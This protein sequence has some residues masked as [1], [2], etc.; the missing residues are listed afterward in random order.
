MIQSG[1][2]GQHMPAYNMYGSLQILN[3]RIRKHSVSRLSGVVNSVS[4]RSQ[5]LAAR[6]S[7]AFSYDTLRIITI[8]RNTAH[9]CCAS[10][11]N[12]AFLNLF[13][14]TEIETIV[15]ICESGVWSRD[16]VLQA[17]MQSDWD[18]EKALALLRE[19]HDSDEPK[20][21]DESRKRGTTLQPEICQCGRSVKRGGAAI[22]CDRCP[23]GHTRDCEK[24]EKELM[25]M[26]TI[27]GSSKVSF[28][29]SAT[30][31][32]IDAGYLVLRTPPELEHHRGLHRCT[33]GSLQQ[34]LGMQISENRTAF[35]IRR[36]GTEE[37]NSD[38]WARQGLQG[39][40]PTH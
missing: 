25:S 5:L 34:R 27:G 19:A 28:S 22:C 24:R 18:K 15:N 16:Q 14:P 9:A 6:R 39:Q 11:M 3:T 26:S 40:P 35:C 33:W 1:A 12:K 13:K 30:A 32:V 21:K 17:A 38:A 37:Q 10:G 20:D 7:R 4:Q 2:G 36:A 31:G 8:R 29:S 23:S